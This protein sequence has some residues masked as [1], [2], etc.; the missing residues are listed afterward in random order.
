AV[1]LAQVALEKLKGDESVLPDLF[2]RWPTQ[3]TIKQFEED[4]EKASYVREAVRPQLQGALSR[5]GRFGNTKAVIGL[6]GWL[7]YQPGVAAVGGPPLLDPAILGSRAKAARD[8]GGDPLYPDPRPAIR[9]FRDY[10]ATRDI[11]LVIFPVPDKAGLQPAQLHGRVDVDRSRDDGGTGTLPGRNPD[12]ERLMAELRAAGVLVFDPTPQRLDPVAAP[13]FL[14]QDT[15]WT[16]EWMKDVSRDLA[17][18]LEANVPLISAMPRRQ[19]ASTAKQISRVGD[20][21]DMLGLPPGQTLFPARTITIEEV[22]AVDGNPF[23]PNP[24]AAV[25]LLGDSFCNV[26]TL[27][28]M[29]WG[30][31]AGLAPHLARALRAD[32]DVIAQND[33][34]AFATRQLLW[35]ELSN[36]EPGKPDR[37]SG[38]K[39]VIWE[40]ASRELAVGN[41]KPLRWPVAPS[42]TPGAGGGP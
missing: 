11:A 32:V 27:G 34:G 16:P 30:E 36:P 15:H 14:Q 23:E 6:D 8:A 29:G 5:F 38:K 31:A 22:H 13:R 2:K 41:W 37:L 42:A 9:G 18:F 24:G 17:T 28:Q 33:A 20:L 4:L 7:F 40:F 39:V 21:V 25:L 1:P 10:L 35:N 12:H 26:F 19:W 3:E